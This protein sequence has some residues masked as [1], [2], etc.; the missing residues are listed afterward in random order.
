MALRAVAA[1]AIAAGFLSAGVLTAVYGVLTVSKRPNATAAPE[2]ALFPWRGPDPSIQAELDALN[3]AAARAAAAEPVMTVSI[4][5][6]PQVAPWSGALAPSD[7]AGR[8]GAAAT[9]PPLPQESSVRLAFDLGPNRGYAAYFHEAAMRTGLSPASLAA[10]IDAEATKKASG[11]WDPAS[12]NPASSARGLAQ[13]LEKT[14]IAEAGKPARLLHAEALR[15]GYIDA[16][17]AVAD[18]SGLLAMRLEPRLAIIAAAEMAVDNLTSLAGSGFRPKDDLDAARLAYLAHHEGRRGARRFLRGEMESGAALKLLE[19][20]IGEARVAAL[21]AEHDGKADAA[22]RDWLS[23]Y[24][25]GKIRPA[26]FL[27]AVN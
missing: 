20:N 18:R 22:Y 3:A 25:G 16:A 10:L 9:P 7:A 21:L 26:R 12:R 15:R 17:G 13:F 19:K 14:W 11:V 1:A 2:A 24:I 8:N 27:R 6:T 23:R 4:P 5:E